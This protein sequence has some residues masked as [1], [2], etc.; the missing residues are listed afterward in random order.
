MTSYTLLNPYRIFSNLFFVYFNIH[1]LVFSTHSLATNQSDILLDIVQNCLNTKTQNYCQQCRAP[2]LLAN[3]SV[4]SSCTSSIEV[5]TENEDFVAMRDI[6]MCG[7]P[8]NFVHGL[9][10]PK[11]IVTG[12]EDD[13]RPDAIWQFAW[14]V[15]EQ[16]MPIHEIAL[17]VNPKSKRSQNQLHVHLV[18]LKQGLNPKLDAAWVGITENLSQVWSFASQAAQARHMNE[19]GVLIALSPQGGYRVALTSE[20]PEWL[21]TQAICT[22]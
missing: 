16:H 10:L 17:A 5:W 20:S 6:K 18:R 8:S 7:C 15:A 9:V 11:T 4:H 1:I 19:Y 14:N 13:R 2:Q 21:F 22:P 3:C 12:I